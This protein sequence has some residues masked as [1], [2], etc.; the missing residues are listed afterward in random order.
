MPDISVGEPWWCDRVA[1]L[2]SAAAHYGD[3]APALVREGLQIL[4]VHRGNYRD[5]V[6]DLQ[7]LQLIW[8]EFPREHWDEIREGGSMNFITKPPA[9]ETPNSP[10]DEEA[11]ALAAGFMD[12]LIE[13][14]AMGPLPDNM[15]PRVI[16]P[17]FAVAMAGQPGQF[18]IIAVCWGRSGLPQ[19]SH[20]H[21][22]T[23]VPWGMV[24]CRRRFK[25]F[26]PVQDPCGGLALPLPSPP[27]HW[28]RQYP[29]WSSNGIFQLPGPWRPLWFGFRPFGTGASERETW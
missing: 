29:L 15:E 3:R 16:A 18:C 6:P 27:S 22:G 14:G 9:R 11:T 8:W 20:A 1:N 19:P 21:S 23:V 24:G 4:D 17:L 12:E 28:P 2:R 7:K 5:G 13:I 26:L 25:I 10:M